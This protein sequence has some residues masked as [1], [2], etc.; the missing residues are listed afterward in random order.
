MSSHNRTLKAII[1]K[2]VVRVSMDKRYM[3]YKSR[4]TRVENLCGKFK[5]RVPKEPF[6][7]AVVVNHTCMGWQEDVFNIHGN[8][9]FMNNLSGIMYFKG[10]RNLQSLHEFASDLGL[11]KPDAVIHMVVFSGCIGKFIDVHPA[12]LMEKILREAGLDPYRLID[13]TNA[14]RFRLKPI[15]WGPANVPR[16]NDWSISTRG[17]FI[18]RMTWKS[19][20]WTQQIEDDLLKFC[21]DI[22]QK[23]KQFLHES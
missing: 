5:C 14:V 2:K 6:K 1:N 19:L 10:C 18:I 17:S 21:D 8:G 22:I 20:I 23:L 4:P 13:T 12:G 16:A 3:L 11:D 15:Q 9:S 7:E